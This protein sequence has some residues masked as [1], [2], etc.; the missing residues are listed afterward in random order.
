MVQNQGGIAIRY[1]TKVEWLYGTRTVPSRN[2]YLGGIVIWN[3]TEVE[4]LHGTEPRWNSHKVQY[5][6]GMVIRYSSMARNHHQV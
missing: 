3:S 6:G 4:K 5:Q 2:G 1:S